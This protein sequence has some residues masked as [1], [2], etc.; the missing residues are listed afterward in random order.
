MNTGHYI[1]AAGHAG[2]IGWL[3]VGGAFAPAPEPFEVSE[4]AVI[5]SEEFAALMAVGQAPSAVVD[6]PS[7]SQPAPSQEAAPDVAA[8]PDPVRP[9]TPP[10]PT[11]I[12]EPDSR[13]DVSTL[14]PPPEAEVSDTAPVL[15][16]PS[17]EVVTLAPR[18]STRPRPRPAPRVAPQPVA[19]PAPDTRVDDVAREEAR[20]DPATQ[21]VREEQD[22]TAPEEAATETVVETQEPASSAPARSTRPR[23]RPRNLRQADATAEASGRSATDDAVSAAL[24]SA[25]DSTGE[26]GARSTQPSGPP[27]TGG[28]KDALRVSVSNCW[29]VG[30]LSSEALRTTVVVGV[31]LDRAGKPVSGSVKML[32]ASGGSNDAARQA[33]G[34]ARR[35]I[36]RCGAS[37]YNLPSEKYDHW[38][39]IEMTFNP[40]KMRIK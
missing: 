29:N 14:V 39:D 34:A 28:E 38:R 20:P 36:I 24:R 19:Q 21:D 9:A 30:A 26:T 18:L 2:L 27:L 37:G 5:S 25:A 32:S 8:Q 10:E 40:E 23:T 6:V 13:P 22:A 16:P 35:A 3:L 15:E 17:E 12:A 11:Q 31:S 33:F 4:V 7:P 1:S